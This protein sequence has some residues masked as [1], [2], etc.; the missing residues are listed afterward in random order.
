MAASSPD[1][2]R[3]SSVLLRD[4]RLWERRA[5]RGRIPPPNLVA[6]WWS[7]IQG[8][9]RS[10]AAE[11]DDLARCLGLI[12]R[13]SVRHA[14]A[15]LERALA[16]YSKGTAAPRVAR[17]D[18]ADWRRD[19][20]RAA[21]LGVAV[22]A[23][24]DRLA[25]VHGQY[26]LA[27]LRQGAGQTDPA[28]P[29]DAKVANPW[30]EVIEG[31][32]SGAVIDLDLVAE[33]IGAFTARPSYQDDASDTAGISAFAARVRAAGQLLNPRPPLAGGWT[34]PASLDALGVFIERARRWLGLSHRHYGP[35]SPIAEGWPPLDLPLVIPFED[36]SDWP[37]EGADVRG[38]MEQTDGITIG[39]P[40]LSD[41]LPGMHGLSV[42][43]ERSS[44]RS[45]ADSPA[46]PPALEQ[47]GLADQTRAQARQAFLGMTSRLSRPR[48]GA[49]PPIPVS[50]GPFPGDPSGHPAGISH[51]Q[52][53]PGRS[54]AAP[55]A[56]RIQIAATVPSRLPL[57]ATL[58]YPAA[59]PAE[60]PA[61]PDLG[62]AVLRAWLSPPA[63]SARGRVHPFIFA[64]LI[65]A[66]PPD[67]QEP[68]SET[69]ELLTGRSPEP[70]HDTTAAP[71][72]AEPP[73]RTL[74]PAP[75]TPSRTPSITAQPTRL[76]PRP[77]AVGIQVS[78]TRPAPGSRPPVLAVAARGTWPSTATD[79]YREE[80]TRIAEIGEAAAVPPVP[81]G[82]IL[83]EPS[84]RTSPA[85]DA[86]GAVGTR[87]VIRIAVD[88]VAGASPWDHPQL[89]ARTAEQF[90]RL[91]THGA[92][93][94][95]MPGR[96]VPE[97][98]YDAAWARPAAL[99]SLPGPRGPIPVGT[100]DLL[101][102]AQIVSQRPGF[103]RVIAAPAT[104]RRLT[105]PT[106]PENTATPHATFPSL[107]LIREGT[108]Q[109]LEALAGAPPVV[110]L[111][112]EQTEIQSIAAVG[113][114][115][116]TDQQRASSESS[117]VPPDLV[118]ALP[119]LRGVR[120][121]AAIPITAVQAVLPRAQ[122]LH[123]HWPETGQGTRAIGERA[124]ALAAAIERAVRWIVTAPLRGILSLPR[125]ELPLIFARPILG[126][127]ESD[128]PAPT[129][130]P[131]PAHRPGAAGD[132][133]IA[134]PGI[135]RGSPILSIPG[136]MDE[137]AGSRAI[138]LSGESGAGGVS[139]R[140]QTGFTDRQTISSVTH[141]LGETT[142]FGPNLLAIRPLSSG[143]LPGITHLLASLLG[144]VPRRTAPPHPALPPLPEPATFL[145]MLTSPWTD[146]PEGVTDGPTQAAAPSSAAGSQ[147][148][149][150]DEGT[151]GGGAHR[152]SSQPVLGDMPGP[153]A[154]AAFAAGMIART[155]SPTGFT[156]RAGIQAAAL[157]W[158]TRRSGIAPGILPPAPFPRT[159]HGDED[160]PADLA[161]QILA[162]FGL[163]VA[164]A[165]PTMTPALLTGEW[166][167]LGT[168]GH[169]TSA[170]SP[171]SG[172]LAGPAPVSRPGEL[173]P[174]RS[175]TP[176]EM[177]RPIQVT[178]FDVT[179][180]ES[181]AAKTV[182]PL[183]GPWPLVPAAG[184]ATVV[185][186]S[187]TRG[188]SD[189]AGVVPFI[190]TGATGSVGY[191]QARAPGPLPIRAQ[192]V[193]RAEIGRP[194]ASAGGMSAPL[195]PEATT[196]TAGQPAPPQP[197]LDAL[198]RQIYAIIKQ[199][200]A[201]ERERSGLA[202]RIRSW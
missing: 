127:T 47:M 94:E 149:A 91:D 67:L 161:R 95:L 139:P 188:Q 146:V 84:G 124:R 85:A 77:A 179:A 80:T 25:R 190:P 126:E 88:W 164:P 83:L 130:V 29:G 115:R 201:V 81:R 191:S 137:Q 121:E 32:L 90:R 183:A 177:V 51:P 158:S 154:L 104:I 27:Q 18:F 162:R 133:K 53:V 145:G 174:G 45:I 128:A 63:A 106:I 156:H 178:V 101:D 108:D 86:P 109:E 142:V 113:S 118:T 43:R 3:V 185:E 100:I 78:E 11:W 44:S 38:S 168:N 187:V 93:I 110:S 150:A 54:R 62:Q 74:R 151:V 59:P 30:D 143:Q 37:D 120:S 192:E 34:P 57:P 125:S 76:Q 169:R 15:T 132:K 160:T 197:D 122:R 14:L 105:R 26:I 9:P 48:I 89:L 39:R 33:L 148:E 31:Q 202:G 28:A 23:E 98:L 114:L 196:Y 153:S 52:R 75:G 97:G 2:G 170:A 21:A 20:E 87:S 41:R 66:P 13:A 189:G 136:R 49:I 42:G 193:A 175:V 165:E 16:A 147:G 176:A 79:E 171:R 129:T 69:D 141:G 8:M 199:R 186:P 180:S 117:S 194:E 1:E 116:G 112:R 103:L 182:G 10:D 7:R 167:I 172:D 173:L 131:I 17:G 46:G 72:D 70:M 58:A 56:S 135:E 111:E 40:A 134:S 64:P 61:P 140:R 36:E 55:P 157:P 82:R 96:A 73:Q 24:R 5:R 12:L 155:A 152:P 198:T 35:G 102:Q 123:T 6:R 184:A 65:F 68:W 159:M 107:P 99:L 71:R 163:P 4:L 138:R 60:S 92:T 166:A 195:V 50:G 119:S 22:S 144:A 181:T 19:L 200:L